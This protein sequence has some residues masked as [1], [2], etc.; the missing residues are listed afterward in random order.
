MPLEQHPARGRGHRGSN[1]QRERTAPG[2]DSPALPDRPD[3]LVLSGKLRF[4]RP[5]I[6]QKNSLYIYYLFERKTIVRKQK[7]ER[8]QAHVPTWHE[9][10]GITPLIRRGGSGNDKGGLPS[11]LAS[12][13]VTRDFVLAMAIWQQAGS[14]WFLPL[15]SAL[16]FSTEYC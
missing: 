5:W 2:N 12:L 8:R 1:S 13:W 6:F 15:Q 9:R 7:S 4:D 10:S 14:S 16:P 11:A 3:H